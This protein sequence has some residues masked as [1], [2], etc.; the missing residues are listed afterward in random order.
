MLL[1]FNVNKWGYRRLE[2]GDFNAYIWKGKRRNTE[3]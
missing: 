2:K 3:I 1:L